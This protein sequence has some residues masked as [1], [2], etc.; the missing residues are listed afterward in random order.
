MKKLGLILVLVVALLATLITGCA[1]EQL[2]QEELEQLVTDVLTANSEVNTCRFDMHTQTLFEQIGGQ[3]HG[4]GTM[5]GTGTGVIDSSNRKME[6]LLNMDINMPENEKQT[7]SMESHVVGGWMYIKMNAPDADEQIMK[8]KLPDGM[9]DKQSEM[10]QQISL[11]Q[12][13][14]S[15]D[16]IGTET[17]NGII[18]Y[19][20]EI[21]PSRS[22]LEALLSEMN[23]PDIEGAENLEFNLA[24]LVKEMSFK[25]WIAKD[26]HLFVRSATSVI[27]E[28]TPEAI[29]AED[30]DF[31]K[32]TMDQTA[33]LDF[34]GYNEAVSIDI[35]AELQE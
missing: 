20:V 29:G 13:A 3:N 9:W 4:N 10:S 31:E 33:E 18:S 17:V 14:E 30:A 21:V 12:S 15:V 28:I 16:Y 25:Q 32:L 26:S 23:M 27:I 6:M 34:Y 22:Y 1:N 8:M 11:L 35:P 24:D 2:S 7:V 19:V 5:E